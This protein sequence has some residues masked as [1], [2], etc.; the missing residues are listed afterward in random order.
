MEL[1]QLGLRAFDL[2][3]QEAAGGNHGPGP[4]AWFLCYSK[5][6]AMGLYHVGLTYVW[7]TTIS[8]CIFKNAPS[9]DC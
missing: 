9:I 3:W 7:K 8:M 2:G 5:E 4:T 6:C 1:R